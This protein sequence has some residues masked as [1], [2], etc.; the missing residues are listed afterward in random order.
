MGAP[1]D[2]GVFFE[3][4]GARRV[5]LPRY[6][7]QRERYW[8]AAGGGVGDVRGVG[9]GVSD[10]PLLGAA[11]PLAGGEGW[12]F[13]GQ[14]SLDR[15]PWLADHA[16]LDT[17]LLVGTAF[18]ELV[19]AAGRG[20]G[21]RG[22]E[23]LTLQAPLVLVPGKAVQLQVA[24]GGPG[25]D[26]RCEVAVYSRPQAGAG[27]AHSQGE[28][29]GWVRHASGVLVADSGAEGESGW[30]SAKG[31]AVE[32][33]LG[34]GSQWP[35]A[36]ARELDVEFLYDRLAEAGFGYGPAFQGVQ[37]AWRTDTEVYAEVALDHDTA[38][39]A[40]GYGIHPALLDA[41]LHGLYLLNDG[42]GLD[43][44][45]VVLPFSLSG[46]SLW[47]AGASSLRVR[48][49]R[50]E[51]DT[52]SLAAFDEAGEPVLSMSS[53][54]L[55]PFEV[56]QL[57]SIQ[58]KSGSLFRNTWVELPVP[59]VAA[60]QP[61]LAVIGDF[62]AIAPVP[63]AGDRYA[64][65]AE[66]IEAIADGVPAPEVVLASTVAGSDGGDLG[67][68]RVRVCSRH[69]RCCRD[70]WQQTRWSTRGWCC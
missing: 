50:G 17:V 8:L 58:D 36:G 69:S 39:D 42:D 47:Q 19:L 43:L 48:L 56:G 20:A 15:Y 12:L 31:T 28:A 6:A 13:T 40:A 14:L 1:V 23:E 37:A 25:E 30:G 54:A 44:T 59:A 46:V 2:W 35:P 57:G 18:L 51:G 32:S 68:L 27:E 41:A 63:G 55:R 45:G 64:D 65:L 61:T 11:V 26:G 22:V 34:L 24:V 4:S 67:W 52:V 53:L 62:E 5:D 33:V 29:G 66:L 9:L 3:G 21:C 16:V 60:E 70:G 38:T 7:F 10:H 49:A